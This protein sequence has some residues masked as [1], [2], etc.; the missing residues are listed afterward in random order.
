MRLVVV[1]RFH[2]SVVLAV[3]LLL[4]GFYTICTIMTNHRGFC[5]AVRTYRVAH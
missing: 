2:T 4:M 5:K 3:Q 1:D